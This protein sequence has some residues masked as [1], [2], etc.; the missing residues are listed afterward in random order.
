M[1]ICTGENLYAQTQERSTSIHNKIKWFCLDGRTRCFSLFSIYSDFA[2]FQSMKNKVQK[3]YEVLRKRY[4]GTT[5]P[6]NKMY[7]EL[8]DRKLHAMYGREVENKVPLLGKLY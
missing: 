6:F 4:L 5:K 8:T 1:H 2:T 7:W 3:N